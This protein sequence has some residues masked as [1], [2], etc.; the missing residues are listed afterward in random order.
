MQ[1]TQEAW[2]WK[3]EALTSG[4]QSKR[5]AAVVAGFEYTFFDMGH[6]GIDLGLLAE[7][8][9]DG[10]DS[11]PSKASP[12][13]YNNDVFLGMRLALNDTQNTELLM[14]MVQ[15]LGNS[16]IRAVAAPRDGCPYLQG[17]NSTGAP[18]VDMR[19]PDAIGRGPWLYHLSPA[20]FR[21]SVPFPIL[22]ATSGPDGVNIAPCPAR[23]WFLPEK[24][25]LWSGC[26]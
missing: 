11:N 22:S 8:L 24:S 26:A 15:D 5:F 21:P 6:Q 3:L 1:I 18:R 4:G 14:G 10:G 7:Y 13:P 17:R 19:V 12:T 20:L 2:L 16:G 25:C 23:T 9:Y